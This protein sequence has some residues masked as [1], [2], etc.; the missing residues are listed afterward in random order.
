[1]TTALPFRSRVRNTARTTA[2]ETRLHI[3]AS[4]IL[5]DDRLEIALRGEFD[6][7]LAAAKRHA[8]KVAASVAIRF[9]CAATCDVVT[10]D[11]SLVFSVSTTGAVR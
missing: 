7:N 11:N 9:G 3:V 8:A 1:M 2:T 6:G 10:D 5:S 4:R